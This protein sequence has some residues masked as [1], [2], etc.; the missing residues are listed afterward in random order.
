MTNLE[1]NPA[2]NIRDAHSG[3]EASHW[4]S[5]AGT[6]DPALAE[7]EAEQARARREAEERA[8]ELAE[9]QAKLVAERASW[10][11]VLERGRA[12]QAK[13]LHGREQLEILR[14]RLA[15]AVEKFNSIFGGFDYSAEWFAMLA[16]D[17]LCPN[18]TD[19]SAFNGVHP[20]EFYGGKIA[21]LETAIARGEALLDDIAQQEG[22]AQAEARAYAK[23][24]G[25]QHA[26]D[27]GEATPAPASEP[28]QVESASAALTDGD[29]PKKGRR[30]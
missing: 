26:F 9:K 5:Y 4:S 29:E 28:E 19:L 2:L 15:S 18:A 11:S 25:I 22:T 14:A 7:L 12:A 1:R 6:H 3:S 20:L 16:M 23:A 17:P 8:R 27:D 13:L 30:K 21:A 10:N 24:N